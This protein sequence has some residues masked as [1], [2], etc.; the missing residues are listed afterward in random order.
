M[1]E[2]WRLSGAGNDFLALVEPAEDPSPE[3]VRAWCRRGISLGADGLFVLRRH[4]FGVRME[5]FNADGGAAALCVN[6]TRCAARLAFELGWAQ[7]RVVVRTGAGELSGR[8]IDEDEI[9]IEAPRPDRPPEP[10][11]LRVD[12]EEHEVW[13]VRVG[14]PHVVIFRQEDPADLPVARLGPALRSHPDLGSEGA[15]VDFVRVR[16]RHEVDLRSYERG[17]EGETLACGTGVLASVAA[18]VAAE[19]FGLPVAARTRG[20]FELSVRGEADGMS[21][22][23]WSLAGDARIV[24]R[25]EILGG[26]EPGVLEP[27]WG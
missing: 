12:E 19:R 13:R 21:I 26:A 16:T 6:G 25:G 7:D 22:R 5:Y 8:R 17:V 10:T 14:V 3:S 18:G 27:G 9:E 23:H 1:R 15:N 4:D 24:A 2:Y 20:G 11:S